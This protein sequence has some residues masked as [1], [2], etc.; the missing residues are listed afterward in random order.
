MKKKKK[1]RIFIIIILLFLLLIGVVAYYYFGRNKM[2]PSEELL[3]PD[4]TAQDWNGDQQLPQNGDNV[5]VALPGF[6]SLNFYAN[7]TSQKVNLYNPEENTVL[8]QI[9]LLAD[10][11]EIYKSGYVEPGK[12]F[13]DI[14]LNE[15]LEV[16]EYAGI[17]KYQCFLD[18]GKEMNGAEVQFNLIVEERK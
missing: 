10:G 7:E 14:E 2:I 12:G 5:S 13:Y 4:Q 11:K 8:L 17:L 3:H 6:K 1:K 18:N 16:G 9:S 15:P